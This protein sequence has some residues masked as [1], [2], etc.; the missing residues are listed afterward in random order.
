MSFGPQEICRICGEINYGGRIVCSPC[1]SMMWWLDDDVEWKS[2]EPVP[3]TTLSVS[4]YIEQRLAARRER[5]R[6]LAA[7]AREAFLVQFPAVPR[8][9]RS[10]LG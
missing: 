6:E 5:Q 1:D 3:G 9:G 4:E 2:G 10:G 7:V 8:S